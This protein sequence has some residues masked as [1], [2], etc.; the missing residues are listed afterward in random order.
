MKVLFAVS[1]C[2]PFAKS[3]G[4]GDVA[5]ALPKEL[6]KL[7]ADV[8]VM[9]PKYSTISDDLLT[10]VKKIKTFYVNV[11]WRRQY[12]GIE[13][14]KHDGITYYLLD[15]E[16]YF[17]RNALYGDFDD[18]ERFAFFS[19]AVLDA[20]PLIPFKPDVIHAHDW[21]TGMVPFL[22]DRQ[23]RAYPFYKNIK[24][25]FTIHNLQ[26]QGL[27]PESVLG[28]LLNLDHQYFTSGELEF[29]GAVSFMKGALLSAN[30]LTT[31]SP[32]YK[33]EIQTPFFGE[34][35]DGLLRDQSFKLSG[36]LNGID[37]DSYH[38][39]KDTYIEKPYSFDTLEDKKLNKAALQKEFN[40]P[41]SEHIPVVAMVTRL[42]E[43]KGLS[44]VKRV[45]HEL[46]NEQNMQLIVLGSGDPEFESY[47]N[48]LASAYPEKTG[49]YIGFS[50]ALAHRI[51]A[52]ADFFLM[53]SL[54]EP[55]G[56]SQLIS[57]QYGTIPIVRETGGLN[58]TVHSWHETEHTGN[59]FTFGAYNAH[60]MKH[61]VER[62]LEHFNNE[63]VWPILQ[64]NA[65][66]GDYS[67]AC[68]AKEY[69]DLYKGLQGRK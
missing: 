15:N 5:G 24:S 69:Y 33:E 58:D 48:Y 26:F 3:G 65:M 12:C 13:T 42:T 7:G 68:S 4:L 43:Q 44:L 27:F 22:L 11:G 16:F 37:T 39:E 25:V 61:T 9:L 56:L 45:M 46:L 2:A 14:V 40:L 29:Y 53:P 66:S 50:E 51:Y 20:L 19:R 36:I 28:D 47:F 49:V 63:E 30:A 1:E 21:H 41:V 10:K 62:A 59:G 35:L 54:F 18:G 6:I 34:K 23:Y 64:E 8:R 57:L 38:P 17:K 31:V 60:D 52:G 32:T 55:C 67:W